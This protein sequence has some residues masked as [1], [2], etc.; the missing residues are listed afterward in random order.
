[1]PLETVSRRDF[2]A[3]SAVG[4]ALASA[5]A[6]A[7]TNAN[8]RLRLGYIGVGGRAQ[9]HIHSGCDLY[10]V[11]GSVEIATV[12][13]VFNRYRDETA[14]RVAAVTGKSPAKTGDYRDILADK[15]IDAVV[16]ATPDHWH[17][18]QTIDAL[19]AGKHVYCEKPMTHSV[20]EAIRVYKAWKE[21]GLV[22]Q[23]GVQSTSLPVW[24]A[25][26]ERINAG[27][28]GKIL[29]YQTEYFR[30]SDLGQWR[31]YKLA[32]DMTPK[33][34]DWKMFL[35]AD[36]GLAPQMPFDRAKFAQWRC[37][38]D[39]G[40]GMFTDLF[41]HRTTSMLKATGLR[42][43]GRVVGAGGIYLE[44]DGRG[45]PDVATVV[46]DFDEGVQGLVTATMCSGETPIKQ[47]IRGHHASAVLGVG[48]GF[49]G[50]DFVAERPQ[51]THDSS[52]VS[53]RV[54]VGGV[55]NS[56]LAHFKN[57]VDAAVAGRPELVNCSPELGAAAMTVVKLGSRSY[58]EG[59]VF[60]FDPDN[61]TYSDGS[62]AWADRWEKMSAEGAAP[63]HVPGWTAGDKG[64]V[65]FPSEYQKLAGPWVNGKDP[66][67]A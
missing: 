17:A 58:R 13:D 52:I 61:L 43:P 32:E 31:Y 5:P 37:Y 26:N 40:A 36:L 27:G 21:S 25:I 2:L 66:A 20:E 60:H 19:Q 57:F 51:V 9:T 65:L 4:A 46:A 45:V 24:G 10:N 16:I 18:K 39:F 64:S 28:F 14:A 38:W 30:N 8:S 62:S 50:Y 47:V 49:S 29:Q 59:K 67:D 23:V 56:S 12:C 41:V 34:I 48:E 44:Y 15:S 11:D 7:Q 22:M 54:K 33:N 55:E 35:G 42:F 53:E 1:M 3:T 6:V 63:R